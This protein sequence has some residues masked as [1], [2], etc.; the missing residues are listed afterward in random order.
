MCMKKRWE[1][2]TK[3]QG[4]GKVRRHDV[5]DVHLACCRDSNYD[6]SD[7]RTGPVTIAIIVFQSNLT[8]S[9]SNNVTHYYIWRWILSDLLAKKV[10]FTCPSSKYCV[11]EESD[12]PVVENKIL[13]RTAWSS[14]TSE[15]SLHLRYIHCT[16]Q[17]CL[18]LTTWRNLDPVTSSS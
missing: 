4:R 17:L 7:S 12:F 6:R 13:R 16:G 15:I 2:G 11:V 3:K 18:I 8:S 10:T 9:S 1:F 5:L 14:L